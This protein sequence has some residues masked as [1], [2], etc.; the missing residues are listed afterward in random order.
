[1]LKTTTET[2]DIGIFSIKPVAPATTIHHYARSRSGLDAGSIFGA[3][4]RQSN[5]TISKIER[6]RRGSDH[7]TNSEIISMY[8]SEGPPSSLSGSLPPRNSESVER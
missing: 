8:G 4:P 3:D 5:G 2:G 1:M 6:R 7:D